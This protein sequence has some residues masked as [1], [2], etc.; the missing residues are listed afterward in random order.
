[1]KKFLCD[2]NEKNYLNAKRKNMNKPIKYNSPTKTKTYMLFAKPLKLIK[3]YL[4]LIVLLPVIIG[5]LWQIIAL[6]SMS[7]S[8]IRFF[9]VT[10][11][12]ADGLLMMLAIIILL[13]VV[14]FFSILEEKVINK[15]QEI[16]KPSFF[17]RYYFIRL[18][19]VLVSFFL[20]TLLFYFFKDELLKIDG[21]LIH[22]IKIVIVVNLVVFLSKFVYFNFES[23]NALDKVY[24]NKTPKMSFMVSVIIIFL[25]FFL[26]SFSPKFYIPHNLENLEKLKKY[27]HGKEIVPQY[28]NDK[29]IFIEHKKEDNS[30]TIQVVPFEELFDK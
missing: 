17:K 25:V 9:S 2:N 1:M 19:L 4:P 22:F 3:E 13:V 26:M 24:E 29:Y 27:N 15:L 14:L 5:G 18:F 7:M 21:S 10:Q 11:L 16:K 6:A 8:Y 30:T 28:F 20:V 12:I 23:T